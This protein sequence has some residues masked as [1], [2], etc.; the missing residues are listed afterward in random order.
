MVALEVLLLWRH[1]LF[2]FAG[3]LSKEKELEKEL[4]R[5]GEGSEDED[6]NEDAKEGTGAEDVNEGT[7][8]ADEDVKEGTEDEDEDVKEGTEDEDVREGVEEGLEEEGVEGEGVE[9]KGAEGEGVEEEGVKVEVEEDCC[10]G[11]L[12]KVGMELDEAIGVVGREKNAGT[13][14]RGVE[15]RL[16]VVAPKR[17]VPGVRGGV[18]GW[19]VG[20][21]EWGGMT[22]GEGATWEWPEMRALVT[23]GSVDDVG[24]GAPVAGGTQGARGDPNPF[25]SRTLFKRRKSFAGLDLGSAISL[26]GEDVAGFE[27]STSMSSSASS[28]FVSVASSSVESV[29]PSAWSDAFSSTPLLWERETEARGLPREESGGRGELGTERAW[30]IKGLRPDPRR[31]E[32]G[33]GLGLGGALWGRDDEDDE[34]ARP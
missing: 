26:L 31:L 7:E 20:W 17:G 9:E 34:P 24:G 18:G 32:P 12:G 23:L 2:S 30:R 21:L 29:A 22:R 13:Q 15:G 33:L 11:K 27:L 28:G 16:P 14:S 5:R 4:D 25:W 6:E 19:G 10:K 3:L 1:V 8:D